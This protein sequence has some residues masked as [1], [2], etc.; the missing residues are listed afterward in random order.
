MEP[1]T[2]RPTG[3]PVQVG[4]AAAEVQQ[5]L[6]FRA[7]TT[8]RHRIPGECPPCPPLSRPLRISEVLP[9]MVSLAHIYFYIYTGLQSYTFPAPSGFIRHPPSYLNVCIQAA[10]LSQFP[11]LYTHLRYYQFGENMEVVWLGSLM[12]S[13]GEPLILT[14]RN[15]CLGL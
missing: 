6:A 15:S 11:W 8:R 4:V 2:E 1:P 12:S 3:C 10:Q 7:L 14:L 9:F 5:C 13:C